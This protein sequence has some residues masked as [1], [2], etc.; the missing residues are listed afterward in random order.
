MPWK[1]LSAKKVRT[2]EPLATSS[3]NDIISIPF[4][5]GLLK[6][7]K[8][9]PRPETDTEAQLYE[10]PVQQGIYKTKLKKN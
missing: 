3:P 7:L 5:A 8:I 1:T 10:D 2:A 6:K 4:V 9:L